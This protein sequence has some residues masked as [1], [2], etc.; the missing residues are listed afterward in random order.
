[1]NI[2]AF[3]EVCK[4][5]TVKT[6]IECL[7]KEFTRNPEAQD[8]LYYTGWL[9]IADKPGDYTIE[10]YCEIAARAMTRKYYLYYMPPAKTCG[11]GYRRNGLDYG[12]VKVRRKLRFFKKVSTKLY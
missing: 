7:S 8:D 6:Y 1:M 9:S 5:A 12:M 3:A 10:A 2:L 4:Y 11:D